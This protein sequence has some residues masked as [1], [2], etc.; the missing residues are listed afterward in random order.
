MVK[1]TAGLFAIVLLAATS[2]SA[3]FK[4]IS[5]SDFANSPARVTA[6]SKAVRGMKAR[7]TLA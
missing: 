1:R 3:Q 4:R 7:N 5:A 2:A 6:L